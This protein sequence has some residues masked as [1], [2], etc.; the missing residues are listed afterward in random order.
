MQEGIHPKI[1]SIIQALYHFSIEFLDEQLEACEQQGS[2]KDTIT[3]QPHSLYSVPDLNKVL[4]LH[5]VRLYTDIFSPYVTSF[6]PLFIILIIK[7]I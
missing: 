7:I 4:N 2:S 5:G 6:R 1:S 3:T